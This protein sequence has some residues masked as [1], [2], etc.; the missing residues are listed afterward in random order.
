VTLQEPAP[1]S[2]TCAP[3][4]LQSPAAA[5]VTARPDDDVALTVTSASPNVLSASVPNVMVWSAF[6][7]TRVVV[8][9]PL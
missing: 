8:R 4:A 7:M 6:P 2:V 5:N 1:V 9:L 3:L